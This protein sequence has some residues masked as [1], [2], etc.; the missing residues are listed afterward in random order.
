VFAARSQK[1]QS[2]KLKKVIPNGS[3]KAILIDPYNTEMKVVAKEG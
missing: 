1:S 3:V 2:P